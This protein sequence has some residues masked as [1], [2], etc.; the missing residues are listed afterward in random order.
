MPA[1]DPKYCERIVDLEVLREALKFTRKVT[2]TSPFSEIV[3]TEVTPGP[4]VQSDEQIDSQSG[5]TVGLS[6]SRAAALIAAIIEFIKGV[7]FSTFRE[8]LVD[9]RL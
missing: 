9:A 1:I 7:L 6:L 4:D 8:C 2:Q 3:D 5:Q